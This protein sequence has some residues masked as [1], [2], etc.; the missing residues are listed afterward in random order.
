MWPRFSKCENST[1]FSYF[2]STVSG[3]YFINGVLDCMDTSRVRDMV[4]IN[5]NFTYYP[6]KDDQISTQKIW[7]NFYQKIILE[8]LLDFSIVINHRHAMT[9][10]RY[11]S[12]GIDIRWNI[13]GILIRKQ[14]FMLCG[15]TVN[16]IPKSSILNLQKFIYATILVYHSRLYRVL[17]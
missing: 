14:L 2:K 8:K 11:G 13:I 15:P 16:W 9:P 7:R 3:L 12:S 10:C 1:K 17:R 5:K 6:R 4:I